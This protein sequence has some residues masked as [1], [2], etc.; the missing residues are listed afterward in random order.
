MARLRPEEPQDSASEDDSSV[1]EQKTR[2][3]AFGGSEPSDS[4]AEESESSD[5]SQAPRRKAHHGAFFDTEALDDSASESDDGEGSDDSGDSDPYGSSGARAKPFWGHAV[6]GPRSFPQ[7]MRLPIE[8]RALIWHYFCD[9]LNVSHRVLEFF[10]RRNVR[11]KWLA[12][13]GNSLLART[14]ASRAMLSVY[15]ETRNLYLG[16]Y[17]HVLDFYTEELKPATFPFNRD[18]DIVMISAGDIDD[19]LKDSGPYSYADG[20]DRFEIPG[21]SDR[22]NH[23][24]VELP[25]SRR[26]DADFIPYQYFLSMPNLKA[27]YPC[28]D[29]DDPQIHVS[30]LKW[31]FSDHAISCHADTEEIEPGFGEDLELIYVWHDPN[32]ECNGEGDCA[33]LTALTGPGSLNAFTGPGSLR[34]NLPDVD[35]DDYNDLSEEARVVWLKEMERLDAIMLC[36][37][38]LFSGYRHNYLLN[39]V[40][41][42]RLPDGTLDEERLVWSEDDDVPEP[43][44]FLDNYDSDGI[45]DAT[46]PEPETDDDEGS[47]IEDDTLAMELGQGWAESSA[48][49]SPVEGEIQTHDH[50]VYTIH[51]SSEEEEAESMEEEEAASPPRSPTKRIRGRQ[52]IEDDSDEDEAGDESVMEIAAPEP[53]RSKKRSRVILSDEEDEEEPAVQSRPAKRARPVVIDDDDEEEDEESDVEEVAQKTRGRGSSTRAPVVLSDSEEEESDDEDEDEPP[54]TLSLAERLRLHR[55]ANPIDDSEE[56]S[57][58]EEDENDYTRGTDEDDSERGSDDLVLGM[59]DDGEEDEDEEEDEYE[60]GYS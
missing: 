5:G 10:I 27:V 52:I 51:D 33:T 47:G 21:L 40:R 4:D 49:F 29:I 38:R 55:E 9:D 30:D 32:A 58:S 17:P 60:D 31:C 36:P 59:A 6:D 19:D 43:D 34:K 48:G 1:I 50:S 18:S 46:V 35:E 12:F 3:V 54:K 45:D 16:R 8:L 39:V 57:R 13:A 24:G 15:H 42:A 22:I 11:G 26:S 56:G 41:Q 7:F 37:M 28:F 25:L 23:L 44:S 2:T 14:A 20:P 53:L